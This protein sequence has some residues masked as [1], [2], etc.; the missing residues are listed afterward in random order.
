MRFIRK[1]VEIC[2]EVSAKTGMLAVFLLLALT[3][4][5]VIGR[6]VF[7]MPI[8][9]TFELI[10]IIFALSAFFSFPVSQFRGENLGI[11]LIYDK[12]PIRLK[13]IL[14][15]SSAIVSIGMF[16]IAFRQTLKY[17]TRMKAANSITSVLRWPMHPWIY[18]AAL[19]LLLLVLALLW[20]LLVSIKELKGEKIDES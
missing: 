4:G 10:K 5:D 6:F 14:D 1:F 11:T 19:G 3:V 12:L 18:I 13:G 20:D 17:A 2:C 15:F 16:S 9:G 8:P 7:N